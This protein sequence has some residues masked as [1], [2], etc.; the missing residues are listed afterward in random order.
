PTGPPVAPERRR[1]GG[2]IEMLVG[3]VTEWSGSVIVCFIT[4]LSTPLPKRVTE[5]L[6]SFNRI[7]WGNPLRLHEFNDWNSR[8]APLRYGPAPTES[9]LWQNRRLPR[10]S[11]HT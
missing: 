1:R 5:G 9:A 8:G 4:I 11:R 10:A 6:D 7:G 3:P 2:L